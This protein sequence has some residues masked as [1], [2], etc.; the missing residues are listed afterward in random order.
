[1]STYYFMV[2]DTHT[3]RTDA[4]SRTAG[5]IGCHM[6]DSEETLLPFIVAHVGCQVRILS[7]DA[8]EVYD[9]RF[10]IWTKENVE[11]MAMRYQKDES[12]NN[13]APLSLGRVYTLVK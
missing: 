10:A 1:M 13:D 5:N 4:A 7:G 6:G 3:E 2:C 9:C 8:P 11:A 12:S